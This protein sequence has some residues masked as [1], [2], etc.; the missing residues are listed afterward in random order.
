MKILANISSEPS[1]A[2]R[3]TANTVSRFCRYTGSSE[4]SLLADAKLKSKSHTMC[5]TVQIERYQTFSMKCDH[6]T[7][8]SPNII[9]FASSE[10]T[11]TGPIPH[12]ATDLDSDC[13]QTFF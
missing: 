5:M 9:S 11:R 3:S 2:I 7:R 13:L 10:E 12:G 6:R 8:F 4:P 1:S